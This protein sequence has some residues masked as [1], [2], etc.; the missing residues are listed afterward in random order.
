MTTLERRVLNLEAIEAA[1]EPEPFTIHVI[2]GRDPDA[3]SM[4]LEFTLGRES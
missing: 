4:D 3:D 2:F 1:A